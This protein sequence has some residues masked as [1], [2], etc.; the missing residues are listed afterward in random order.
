[1]TQQKNVVEMQN[2]SV[3]YGNCTGANNVMSAISISTQITQYMVTMIIAIGT[4]RGAG[5]A[6]VIAMAVNAELKP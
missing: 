6:S 5:N 1:M 4:P 3:R 2:G